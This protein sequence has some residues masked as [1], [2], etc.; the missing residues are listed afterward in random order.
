MKLNE[1]LQQTKAKQQDIVG[2]INLLDEQ[3]QRLLQEV[4]RLDG[5]VR[6]LTRLN[7]DEEEIK[8]PTESK[9][10]VKL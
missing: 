8:K 4:L 9:T 1:E 7:K 10:K 6:L 2:Q 5:E 3:K